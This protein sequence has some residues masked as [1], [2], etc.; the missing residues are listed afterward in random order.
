LNNATGLITS[1]TL[2]N[3]LLAA[4]KKIMTV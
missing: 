4:R 3:T 1:Y 2:L